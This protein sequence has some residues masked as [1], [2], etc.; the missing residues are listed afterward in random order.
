MFCKAIPYEGA[1]PYL[2]IS[3]CHADAEEVYPLIEELA[4]GKYRVWYDDG[5]HP[6]DD[7]P[8]VIA[9]HLS[10]SAA[11][12]AILSRNASASH[13]CRK[14]MTFALQQKKK[15]IP[16]MLSPVIL[17]L[18]QKM[19]LS[20]CQILTK[21]QSE[22]IPELTDRL[23]KAGQ[24]TECRGISAML[25]EEVGAKTPDVKEAYT[26]FT[27]E[28]YDDA[29]EMSV[30]IRPNRH[31][32]EKTAEPAP[33]PENEP[34]K[35]PEQPEE[36][37]EPTAPGLGS[38]SGGPTPPAPAEGPAIPKDVPA[39]PAE[40]QAPVLF[41]SEDMWG[42]EDTVHLAGEEPAPNGDETV[43]IQP[44]PA[45]DAGEKT[46]RIVRREEWDAALI[47]LESG[48]L[49]KLEKK[50]VRLGRTKGDI[51]INNPKVSSLHAALYCAKEGM[52]IEDLDSTNGT[53][54]SCAELEP[55][56]KTPLS[57]CAPIVLGD[58]SV[59]ICAFGEEAR[60]IF[61][62]NEFSYLVSTE[63]G[64]IHPLS[65]APLSLGRSYAWPGG[66]LSDKRVSRFHGTITYSENGYAFE[67]SPRETT[68]DTLFNGIK[69]LPDSTV[70]LRT[71]DVL[72][73]GDIQHIVFKTLTFDF[74]E[75][76]K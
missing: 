39:A 41:D 52:Q 21:R 36:E 51:Q 4:A 44:E 10:N 48:T 35:E 11:V 62:R 27:E 42:D 69:L 6:G 71:G 67:T 22:E 12:I 43:R 61:S 31:P 29:G 2:F 38:I 70:E 65:Q 40:A 28:L 47:V 16:V 54:L 7:W 50:E 20:E 23:T 64:E 37:K 26:L 8:E 5:I 58:D 73:I 72:S 17:S 68:N 46:V 15:V 32:Q 24:L 18:G 19:Q 63:T 76:I 13:N 60:R 33:V 9:N 55:N 59:C 49:Y 1:E 56:V 25:R 74:V 66:T 45:E 14:E 34:E 75:T 3:Y 30:V 57:D 53:S